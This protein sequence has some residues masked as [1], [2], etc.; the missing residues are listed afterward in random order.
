MV[1]EYKKNDYLITTDKR[2]LQ[3]KV[4][5]HFLTNSYWDK[6]CSFEVVKKKIKNSFC[7]GI[8]HNKKQIGFCR[9]IS[10]F[11][12]FSY[13]LDVFVIEEY[14]GRGLSKWLM[15][16]VMKQPALSKTESWMLKTADAH[17]LYEKF[18]FKV[19][20]NPEKIMEKKT[21]TKGT[22]KKAK[23]SNCKT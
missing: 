15:S 3:T 7:Y 2:K 16:C 9:I 6:G 4:I 1:Y 20:S 22:N 23:S 12:A 13:L 17:G 8:Y 5:H 19:A 10:D 18:G 11:V 14:R 21:E